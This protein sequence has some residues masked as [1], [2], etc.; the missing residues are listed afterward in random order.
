[1]LSA[2]LS[3]EQQVDILSQ[4]GMHQ[5]DGLFGDEIEDDEL[6]ASSHEV[7]SSDEQMWI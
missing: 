5:I 2:I 7:L 1:M 6:L 3:T 4:N